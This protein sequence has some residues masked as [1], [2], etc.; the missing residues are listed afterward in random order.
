MIN[1]PDVPE[2]GGGT[3]AAPVF[4]RVIGGALRLLNVPPDEA[5]LEV[6]ALDGAAS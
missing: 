6:A 1:D 2:A 3:I 4:S 5:A